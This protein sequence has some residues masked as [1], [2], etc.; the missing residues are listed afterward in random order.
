MLE[1][2]AKIAEMEACKAC[3]GDEDCLE[4]LEC[5]PPKKDKKK[6]SALAQG[7][8]GDMDWVDPCAGFE[9][10]ADAYTKCWD[11]EAA[12]M[13]KEMKEQLA[14]MEAEM[15]EQ[16]KKAAMEACKSL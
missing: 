4:A 3:K 1:K 7:T 9:G 5:P 11:E 8:G 2:E 6:K 14:K 12:R 13:E 15:K 16:M 10:D